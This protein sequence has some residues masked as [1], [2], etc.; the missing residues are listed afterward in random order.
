[1][2]QMAV[3]VTLIV[4]PLS[5]LEGYRR[6]KKAGLAEA[7]R[8]CEECGGSYTAGHYKQHTIVSRNHRHG[9][10]LHDALEAHRGVRNN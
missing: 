9:E 10:A 7:F 6:G 8:V 1:M 3:L 5:F 4:L 2:S